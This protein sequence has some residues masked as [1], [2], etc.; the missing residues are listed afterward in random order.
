VGLE[1]DRVQS[2][3]VLLSEGHQQLVRYLALLAAQVLGV[4]DVLEKGL[5]GLV[6][7][8]VVGERKRRGEEERRGEGGERPVRSRPS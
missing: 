7:G 8:E 4:A 3:E 6:E 2:I 1:L 5:I